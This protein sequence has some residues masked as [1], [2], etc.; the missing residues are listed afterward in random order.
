VNGALA[1]SRGL[2]CLSR[3]WL[4][5]ALGLIAASAQ[6]AG[7]AMVTDLQGKAVASSAGRSADMTIL[8]DI[9]PGTRVELAAGAT[10]V[11][12]YLDSGDEYVFKGPAAIEFRPGQPQVLSG[13]PPERR[14]LDLGKGAKPIR[15]KPVGMTQG[16]IVMRG[17]RPDPRL[18]LLNLNRTRTLDTAPVFLWSELQPGQKYGFELRDDTGRVVYETE[19]SATSVKLPSTL[20]LAEG[21]A[22]TWAVSAR[23][24]DGRKYSSTAEFALAAADVRAEA[25]ALRP[26]ASSPLSTRVAY[27]AWLEQMGLKDEARKYWKAAAAERPEDTR[28]RSLSAP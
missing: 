6:A 7:V 18:Q 26:P 14:S 16:A 17:I 9:E 23:L 13:A 12:L 27:A 28:L 10:L 21:A 8:A 11:A 5:C 25:E 1:R 15:I 20:R 2:R 3:W 24:Q 19:V 22:Y 4:A